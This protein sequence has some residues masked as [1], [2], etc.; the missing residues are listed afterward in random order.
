[1]RCLSFFIGSECFAVDVTLVRKVA[2]KLTVTPV[3]AVPDAIIGIANIKGRVV[4]LFSLSKLFKHKETR[5]EKYAA[6]TVD[7]VIFKSFSGGEDQIGLAIDK[8]GNLIEIND[9]LISLPSLTAG[10]EESFCISGIS[11]VDNVLY[12]II[13][14]ESIME[15]YKYTGEKTANTMLTGGNESDEQN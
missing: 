4:T 14:I 7:A 1:M 5:G 12:R 15:R 13:S 2:R 9:D 10:T 8:P 3:P 6:D 11:E